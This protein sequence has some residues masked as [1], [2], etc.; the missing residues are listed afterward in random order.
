[1]TEEEFRERFR[2]TALW[3]SRRR[4]L[5]RNAAIVLGNQRFH[6]AIQALS[7]GLHDSE[8]VVRGACAWALGQI[9]GSLAAEALT[10]RLAIESDR[11]VRQE[12][13][14][15]IEASKAGSEP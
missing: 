10:R 15:A 14:L 6:V 12:I 7:R 1:M 11:E 2:H 5:L 3:R 4:G 9:G 8:P 13:Q